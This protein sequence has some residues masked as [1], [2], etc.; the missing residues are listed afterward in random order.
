MIAE[1]GRRGVPLVR[2]RYEDMV[3]DPRAALAAVLE[4]MGEPVTEEALV[5]LHDGSI[6]TGHSHAAEG[7]RVRLQTGRLPLR[8]DESWRPRSR[9]GCSAPSGWWPAR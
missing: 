3:A 4:L 7:G 8:L 9:R 5:V 6:S 1:L 2:V